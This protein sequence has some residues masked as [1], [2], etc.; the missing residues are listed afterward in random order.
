MDIH[1]STCIENITSHIRNIIFDINKSNTQNIKTLY[2][3]F[4]IEIQIDPSY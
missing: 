1:T 3:L 2:D 4:N